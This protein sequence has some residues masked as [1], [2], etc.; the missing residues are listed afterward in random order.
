VDFISTPVVSGF[1]T[2]TSFI[3]IVAQLKHMGG[4]KFRVRGFLNRL[5]ALWTH[6]PE[7]QAGDAI[8][9]LCSVLFLLTLKVE[10][11]VHSA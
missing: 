3:V 9:G 7:V 4:L 11:I 5:H 8:L 10:D 2:A 6:L 1:T